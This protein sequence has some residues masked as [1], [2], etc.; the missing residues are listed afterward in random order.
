MTTPQGKTKHDR[1]ARNTPPTATKKNKDGPTQV[2]PVCESTIVD[3]DE[4][5][6]GED[7]KG[8]CMG[9]S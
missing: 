4:L 5:N 9:W 7:V 8:W 1:P 6:E 2:C 3:N